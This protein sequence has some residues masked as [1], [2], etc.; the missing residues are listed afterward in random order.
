MDDALPDEALVCRGGTCTA[1][2][3][4]KGAGVTLDAVGCLYGVSVNSAAS[5]D[6]AE[7]SASIPNRRIGVTTVGDVRAA[8]GEVTAASTVNNPDHCHLH[9]ISA[10]VAET[11]FSPTVRNPNR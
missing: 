3:F 5:K 11:L 10:K 2:R 8:G 1:D 4:E 6:P 9:G 7:L